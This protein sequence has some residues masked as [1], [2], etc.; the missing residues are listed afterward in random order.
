MS[1][2][3]IQELEIKLTFLERHVEEQDRVIYDMQNR[4]EKL[5]RKFEQMENRL[6]SSSDSSSGTL[7]ADER[8]PHY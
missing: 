3:S 6:E 5:Q 2:L 7:P 8:P 4:L 1:D